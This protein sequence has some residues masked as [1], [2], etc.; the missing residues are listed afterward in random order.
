MRIHIIL[1]W[2][3]YNDDENNN[4][5]T[6]HTGTILH[7]SAVSIS[8]RDSYTSLR[9]V[10]VTPIGVGNTTETVHGSLV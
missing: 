10:K 9:F 6:C 5:S 4:N 2:I 7:L 1:F 8:N 3:C